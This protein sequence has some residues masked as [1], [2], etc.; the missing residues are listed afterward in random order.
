VD[1][2]W[3]K[4][5]FNHPMLERRRG[6]LPCW[7][8]GRGPGRKSERPDERSDVRSQ[9]PEPLQT[10]IWADYGWLESVDWGAEGEAIGCD[11]VVVL[12]ELGQGIATLPKVCRSHRAT[13][14]IRSLASSPA[15]SEECH[16]VIKGGT[17]RVPTAALAR[18]P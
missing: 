17:D 9:A 10:R 6:F 2:A 14:D 1:L 15:C 7:A 11:P 3:P 8:T 5:H 4:G 12:E 18:V 13:C 16:S